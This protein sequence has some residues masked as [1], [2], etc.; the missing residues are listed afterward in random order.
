MSNRLSKGKVRVGSLACDTS[1]GVWF[2]SDLAK[3]NVMAVPFT[4]TG[5]SEV[6]TG[7]DLPD[8]AVVHDVWVK[9]TTASTASGTISVGLFSSSSGGDADGFIASL[10]TSST[11]IA[12]PRLTY[13]A[14]TSGDIVTGNKRGALISAHAT[15]TTDLGSWGYYAEHDFATDSVTAKSV[16]YTA[17]ST[18]GTAG[19][20]FFA[21][22]EI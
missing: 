19:Y 12:I 20:V 9:I 7:Y 4:C 13:T 17:N 2:G 10:G 6:D 21:Y 16:T 3:K 14:A 5:T 1:G 8:S 11:G 18:S 22:T 15:G